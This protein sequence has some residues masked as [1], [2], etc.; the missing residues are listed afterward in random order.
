[1]HYLLAKAN[2]RLL[3]LKFNIEIMKEGGTLYCLLRKASNNT[4]V[5]YSIFRLEILKTGGCF[6]RSALIIV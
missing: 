5:Q 3:V 6:P 1:M 4:A 2:L